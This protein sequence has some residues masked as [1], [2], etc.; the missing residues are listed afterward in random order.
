MTDPASESLSL[1]AEFPAATRA[2]WLQAVERVLK[3]ARFEERL[4][5]K[6]A[7]GLA[8]QPLYAPDPAPPIA[9]RAPGARWQVMARIDHPDPAAANAQVLHEL[10]H[11]ADGIVL[12]GAGAAGAHGFG[13]L[14]SPDAM[15]RL[16]A[17]VQLDAGIAI[18]FDL[19][20]QSNDLPLALAAMIKQRNIAREA[21]DIR[22]GFD[23]LGA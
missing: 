22:F 7:D 19:S 14:P 1:A 8:T 12:V 11:G 2:Q 3:G 21:I 9:A 23:P 16:L 5:A 17:G 6:S 15:E 10:E 13:L 20:P 4:V 18:G